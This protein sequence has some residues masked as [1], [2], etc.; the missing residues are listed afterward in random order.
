[1]LRR[2]TR[3][4]NGAQSTVEYTVLIAVVCIVIVGVQVYTK[5][6]VQG[7]LKAGADS[8]GEQFSPRW[9]NFTATTTT[10]LRAHNTFSSNGEG[11]STL[12]D[13]EMTQHKGYVDNFSD[14][15]LT[16][17]GLFE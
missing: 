10:H 7:S 14:R 17:E 16:E 11:L 1:M 15:K 5:R 13:P 9:S 4:A 3:G 12:R 2:M 8:V 6:A